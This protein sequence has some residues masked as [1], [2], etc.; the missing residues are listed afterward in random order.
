M[1]ESCSR[2][3]VFKYKFTIKPVISCELDSH[4]YSNITKKV[5]GLNNDLS[6]PLA[7]RLDK[8]TIWSG[9]EHIFF[10]NRI[11]AVETVEYS[12]AVFLSEKV[13]FPSE[14]A[15]LALKINSFARHDDTGLSCPLFP[16]SLVF[17][18]FG[19]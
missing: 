3:R 13:C 12:S 19:S 4:K 10:A 8:T 16:F 2:R 6:C 9:L 14:K 17:F 15:K 11:S 18:F 7:R 1:R 5:C